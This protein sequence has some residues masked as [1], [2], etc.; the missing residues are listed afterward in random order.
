MKLA[1]DSKKRVD[2]SDGGYHRERSDDLYHTFRW[3]KMAKAWR[4]SHPLCEECKK[5]GVIK[6]GTVTDHVIPWPVCGEFFRQDNLQTL[7]EECN[8]L[9]GQRD[10]ALI[11]EYRLTHKNG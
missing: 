5:R 3:T 8:N 1:W 6:L 2:R 7:C 4:D 9:K 11:R 10:K